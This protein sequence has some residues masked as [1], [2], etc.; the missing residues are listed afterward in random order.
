ML[1]SRIPRLSRLHLFSRTV[2]QDSSPRAFF[3]ALFVALV[4]GLGLVLQFAAIA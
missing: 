1:H 3:L 4:V 2:P